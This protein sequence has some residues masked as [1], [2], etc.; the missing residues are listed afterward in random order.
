MHYTSFVIV[1]FIMSSC[2]PTICS[3]S[4]RYKLYFSMPIGFIKRLLSNSTHAQFLIQADHLANDK[5]GLNLAL[6][7]KRVLSCCN[8]SLSTCVYNLDIQLSLYIPYS[9]KCWQEQILANS[10]V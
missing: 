2:I 9:R 3:Y 7:L 5:K 10:A 1:L 8:D 6:L 4:Y